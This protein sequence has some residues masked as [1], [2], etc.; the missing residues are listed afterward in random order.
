MTST[1]SATQPSSLDLDQL[2]ALLSPDQRAELVAKARI[3]SNRRPAGKRNRDTTGLAAE[4]IR[5]LAGEFDLHLAS[6][7]KSDKTR[8]IYTEAVWNLAEFLAA[9]GMPTD[10]RK[11]GKEHLEAFMVALNS[12]VRAATA[13]QR[14]RSLQQ[15]WKWAQ[16]ERLTDGRT[17]NPMG[18][19]SPPAIP[20]TP[21]PVVDA[22]DLK[23][24]LK[25]CEGKGLERT[26]DMAMIRLLID[27]GCRAGEIVGL[28]EEH[29]DTQSRT[30]YVTGKAGKA[31]YVRYGLKTGQALARYK[32]E[33]ARSMHAASEWLWLGK[34]GQVT[35]SGLRQILT[36]RSQM[37][38]I[39]HIHPHQLRHTWA[40]MMASTGAHETDV[41]Q[42]AGWSSRQM[43]SRYGRSAA[44]ERAL[45]NYSARGT[46]GDRL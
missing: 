16:A 31:R 46:L 14:F 1:G 32:R 29:L 11:I 44:S 10:V 8:R 3:T 38:G 23:A 45:A 12:Q 43:L 33:R 17:G 4:D 25:A 26:R 19:M 13:N 42:L 36:K 40:H 5:V 9:Q 22:D 20:D 24:L 35:D 6:S 34:R 28:K 7:R 39:E 18:N 21:P 2:L 15:F 27:T 37:A 41:M 30:V